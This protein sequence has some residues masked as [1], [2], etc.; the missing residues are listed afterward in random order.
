MGLFHYLR[1]SQDTGAGSK[2]TTSTTDLGT[3]NAGSVRVGYG[4][5]DAVIV[6]IALGAYRS[7]Q[8]NGSAPI[9]SSNNSAVTLAP[10]VQYVP[11]GLPL[12]VSAWL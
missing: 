2:A 8:Y 1:I 5:T 6:A 9:P 4:I 11:P 7:H 3:L 12:Y 10:A